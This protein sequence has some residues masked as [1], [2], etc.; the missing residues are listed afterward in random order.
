VYLHAPTVNF[1][2]PTD[3]DT[4]T[5]EQGG[6]FD[7]PEDGGPW[8][9]PRSLE[10]SQLIARMRH[11]PH[12]L[13]DY[14]YEVSTGPLVWNRHK[15]QRADKPSKSAFPLIWAESVTA[16]GRFQFRADK[17]NHAPYFK[18]KEGD[19]WLITRKPCVLLQR[20][21]AKEQ[22]RRLIAAELPVTF[23]QKHKAVVIENHINM[24]R[25][26]VESPAV[27]ATVM[28]G[29]LNSAIVDAAFRC[30]SGSVAVSAYELE[31][32]PLPSPADLK[33]VL[34][35]KTSREAIAKAAQLLYTQDGE[36]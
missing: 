4:L 11:M 27:S 31:N 8:Q 10:Q 1:I 36:E 17:K 28:A 25:P 16:D 30:I 15:D 26:C 3:Q 12:R 19:D 22:S 24:I 2:A 18:T 23:L 7:L 29:L 14:G 35:R 32:L 9:V 33:R 34:G 13:K 20:T 21:T 5:V 6:T